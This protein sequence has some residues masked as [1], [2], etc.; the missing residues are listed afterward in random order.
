MIDEK[1]DHASMNARA[2]DSMSANA[3][4][5]TDARANASTNASIDASMN[6]NTLKLTLN[7][8]FYSTTVLCQHEHQS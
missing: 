7:T 2:N 5:N 8:L 4:A 6:A 3:N 1:Y